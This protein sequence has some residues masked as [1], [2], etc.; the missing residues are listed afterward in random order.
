MESIELRPKVVALTDHTPSDPSSDNLLVAFLEWADA[1]GIE[2][3]PHQE[4]AV[5]AL[6]SGDNV[7]LATPTGS[8]KS[9]VALAGAFADILYRASAAI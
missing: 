5:L 1:A 2:P 7:V 9:M 4:E 8:G 3:Y 6:L